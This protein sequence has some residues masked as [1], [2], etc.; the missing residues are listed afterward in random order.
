V[1]SWGAGGETPTLDLLAEPP[2]TDGPLPSHLAD[3]VSCVAAWLDA[4]AARLRL[5]HCD[6]GLATPACPL[7]SFDPRR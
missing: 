6:G 7:P 1:R 3:E 2:S 4:E 5:E